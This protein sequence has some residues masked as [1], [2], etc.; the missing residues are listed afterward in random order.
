MDIQDLETLATEVLQQFE[1]GEVERH[2]LHEKVRQTLSQMRAFG[3]PLPDDLVALEQ[4]LEREFE[5][6]VKET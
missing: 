2:E 1:S 5:D 4:E 3:M 6:E